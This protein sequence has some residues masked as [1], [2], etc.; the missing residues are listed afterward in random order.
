MAHHQKGL[1]RWLSG[2]E[3]TCQCQRHGFDPQCE[4]IAW[5]RKWQHT[6]LLLPQR[7]HGQRSGLSSM[8]SRR[9][10][11]NVSVTI[12]NRKPKVCLSC[13]QDVGH[14]SEGWYKAVLLLLLLL[15]HFHKSCL[16]ELSGVVK[17][18]QQRETEVHQQ[19]PRE[20]TRQELE[21]SR[22]R[23]ASG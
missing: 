4:K 10:G 6:P 17:R 23:S 9:V 3:S 21:T 11:L 13:E 5:R 18:L 7:S 22:Q 14:T 20:L 12:I 16:K 2:K 8:G 1:P 15:S 19:M